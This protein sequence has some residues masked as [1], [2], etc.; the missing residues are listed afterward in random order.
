INFIKKFIDKMIVIFRFEEDLYKKA[1]VPVRYVGH[2][3]LDI[4]RTE[5][6]RPEFLQ[7]LTG[8]APD[9]KI[10]AI[11]PG[12][13]KREITTLLPIIAESA[14]IIHERFPKYKFLVSISPTVDIDIYKAILRKY[15]FPMWLVRDETYD[16]INACD[17]ALVASGTATLETAILAKPMLIIY[18]LSAIEYLLAK[19]LMLVSH[20]GLVNVVAGEKIVPEFVQF[21]A[22]PRMIADEAMSI[23]ENRDKYDSIKSKLLRIKETLYPEGASQKAADSI[24]EFLKK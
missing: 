14:K 1:G 23:L 22:R 6:T 15:S 10:I 11:L 3:L 24:L 2:P 16:I 7:K 5:L 12:S 13:R 17:L 8:A 4:V 19:P 20:I 18:K 21:K 9:D